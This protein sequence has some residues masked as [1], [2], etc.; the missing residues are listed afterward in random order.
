LN[1]EMH[2]C[3]LVKKGTTT[4]SAMAMYFKYFVTLY[5]AFEKREQVVSIYFIERFCCL[6]RWFSRE[7]I[8]WLKASLRLMFVGR[9]S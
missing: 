6:I 1:Y 2:H 5:I 3:G 9:S 7:I 8:C 4:S